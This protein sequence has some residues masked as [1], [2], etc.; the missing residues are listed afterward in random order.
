MLEMVPLPLGF[1]EIHA[2]DLTHWNGDSDND[3]GFLVLI[4]TLRARFNA[5][6]SPAA[7]RQRRVSPAHVHQPTIGNT[8]AVNIAANSGS[9]NIGIQNGMET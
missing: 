4:D 7:E 8:G 1:G 2:L 6:P 9:I 3:D 5:I